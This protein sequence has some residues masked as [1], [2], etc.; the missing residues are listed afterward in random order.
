MIFTELPCD[1]ATRFMCH[2]AHLLSSL[3][4]HEIILNLYVV[5]Y[6]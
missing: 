1:D 3:L 6:N 5:G 2:K 4:E